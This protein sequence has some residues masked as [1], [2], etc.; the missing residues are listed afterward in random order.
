MNRIN[1]L[2]TGGFPTDLDTYDFMQAAYTQLQKLAYS[3]AG[4]K[5]CIVSGCEEG[6]GSVTEG[7]VIID[8]ELLKFETQPLGT[9]VTIE[10]TVTAVTFQNGDSKDSFY[11][12][13]AVFGLSGTPWADFVRIPVLAQIESKQRKQLEK[14]VEFLNRTS[15]QTM[16]T[17]ITVTKTGDDY[18]HTAG[19]VCYD[20][21]IYTVDELTVALTDTGTPKFA[22]D[23]DSEYEYK[24]KLVLST[25]PAGLFDYTALT[26]HYG[27]WQSSTSTVG[28]NVISPTGTVTGLTRRWKELP[29]NLILLNF[30]LVLNFSGSST[31]LSILVPLPVAGKEY[32]HEYGVCNVELVAQSRFISATIKRIY[33]VADRLQIQCS[34]TAMTGNTGIYGQIIY[35]KG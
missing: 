16:L 23:T 3:L 28:V 30:A 2:Q 11:D 19:S 8:G 6:G 17:P 31:S 29:G 25:S 1:F 26:N 20:G 21:I 33:A 10:E 15:N 32:Q 5:P 7:Y 4:D 9:F 35:E 22:I 14:L 34:S 24:L 18:T 13:K 12:R 27:A